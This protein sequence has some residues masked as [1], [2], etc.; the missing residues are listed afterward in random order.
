VGR[1]IVATLTN[2]AKSAGCYKVTRHHVVVVLPAQ[3]PQAHQVVLDCNDANIGFY[4]KVD[5]PPP[6]L[7]LLPNAQL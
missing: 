5:L 4:E 7:L 3:S 1:K 2:L 6:P